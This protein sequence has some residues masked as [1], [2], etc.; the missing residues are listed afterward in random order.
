MARYTKSRDWGFPRWRGYSDN[1]HAA[2]KI[3]LCDREGCDKPG[4]FPAPKSPNNPDRWYFCEDHIVEYNRSWDYFAGLSKEEAAKRKA[5]EK[6]QA[7]GYSS[8]SYSWAGSET[9]RSNEV[10]EALKI[11]ELEAD[12]DFEMVKIQWR[13]LA[14]KWHPDLNQNDEKAVKHFHAIQAAFDLLRNREER[15]SF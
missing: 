14:K 7:S 2:K 1:N 3:R 12:A 13:Q 4:N 5:E 9:G 6:R 11:L 8:T 10:L 15:G